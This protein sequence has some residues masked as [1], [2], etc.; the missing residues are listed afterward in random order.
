VGIP[1]GF[2]E[3]IAIWRACAVMV[4]HN[5]IRSSEAPYS[6]IEYRWANS[7]INIVNN[8]MS[9][10]ILQRE[11]A[12]AS[13]TTNVQQVESSVFA[14]E[15]DF[16]LAETSSELKGTAIEA[17]DTDIEGDPRGTLPEVGADEVVD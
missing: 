9:G 2:E 11:D 15:G 1:D 14:G 3:G 7:G 13:L 4:A 16:R 6:S 12:S 10:Q 8:L 17:V 5:T